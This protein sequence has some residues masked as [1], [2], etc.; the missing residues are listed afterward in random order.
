V[1]DIAV[2]AGTSCSAAEAARH[3]SI[4]AEATRHLCQWQLQALGVLQLRTA[5]KHDPCEGSAA[6]LENCRALTTG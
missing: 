1:P 3:L 2:K 5:V 4:A 6:H